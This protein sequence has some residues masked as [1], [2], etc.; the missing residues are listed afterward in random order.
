MIA[1]SLAGLILFS[2]A[3]IFPFLS[4]EFGNQAADT[5]LVTGVRELYAQGNRLLSVL[6][7]FTCILAPLV[8]LLLMLYI[9]LPIRFGRSA[10]YKKPA[11][12]LLKHIRDWNMI[13]VFMLGILVSLVKLAKM[14]TLVPGVAMWSFMALIFV[15]TAASSSIDDR[16]LWQTGHHE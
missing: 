1:L 3:N 14:A 5:A 2:L 10:Q 7:F 12:R 13:E 8:Q 15:I 4:F 16:V 6:V 9:F 11:Y